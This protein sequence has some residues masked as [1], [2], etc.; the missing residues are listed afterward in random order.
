M[1]KQPLGRNLKAITQE[2]GG[3]KR[4]ADAN[5][6]PVK[7]K[8]EDSKERVTT[9]VTIYRELRDKMLDDPISLSGF[10][11]KYLPKYLAGEI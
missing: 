4:S 1:A 5:K 6:Q 3:L 11:N 2:E 9:S 7:E 10:I 8:A